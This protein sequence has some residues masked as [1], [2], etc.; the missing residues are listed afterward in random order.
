MN[1]EP[2]GQS[3]ECPCGTVLR[4]VNAEAVVAAAR[5]HARGVHDMDL[6]DEDARAMVRP[7]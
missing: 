3:I 4:G 5:T 1:D 6:S 7:T 2:V